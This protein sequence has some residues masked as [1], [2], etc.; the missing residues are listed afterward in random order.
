MVIAENPRFEGSEPDLGSRAVIVLHANRAMCLL[1]AGEAEA[2]I[3]QC[4]KGLRLPGVIMET[5]MHAKILARKMNALLDCGPW[6]PLPYFAYKAANN[7][8][9][10]HIKQQIIRKPFI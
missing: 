8:E 10:L 4:D 2:A 5:S 3:E 9:T 7:K 6:N 1:K